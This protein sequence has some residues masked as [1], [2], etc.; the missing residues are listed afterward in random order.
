MAFGKPDDTY[1]RQGGDRS[2]QKGPQYPNLQDSNPLQRVR[3]TYRMPQEDAYKM[4]GGRF[5]PA[6][7]PN[8][9]DMQSDGRATVRDGGYQPG[10]QNFDKRATSFKS[11]DDNLRMQWIDTGP[12]NP[13]E[14]RK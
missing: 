10:D 11:L 2:G 8:A 9:V 5:M 12:V 7:N 13:S 1:G 4:Q 6:V 3:D 14:G